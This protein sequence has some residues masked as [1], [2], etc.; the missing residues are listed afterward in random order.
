[1]TPYVFSI[2]FF[3]VSAIL[4]WLV[5]PLFHLHGSTLLVLRLL[6]ISVGTAA[7][8]AV[9]AVQ[10]R[11]KSSPASEAEV[12]DAS[13]LGTLMR[14]AQQRLAASQRASAK[15]FDSTSLVYILGGPNAA[16]T[17]IALRS[18]LD[19]ELLA[20][21]VYRDQTVVATPLSTFWY[22]QHCVLVEAG[23][24][25]RSS[26]HLWETLVRRTRPR[27]Y[28]S[29]LGAT[30][31]TRAAVVCV[32][33]ESFF[34]SDARESIADLARSTN[35]MVRTLARQLG[36]DL[37]VYVIFTKLDRVPGFAEFVRHLST[38][39]V[40]E[41]LGV[42]LP[43]SSV[44]GGLYA[45]HA[46]AAVTLSLDELFFSLR[47]F[48]VEALARQSDQPTTAP[49]YEFPRE[50][51][52]LRNNLASYL[53]ELTRPSHLSA[54]PYL[55]G[56]YF[57]GVRAH[58]SEQAV[59]A[60]AAVRKQV[61]VDSDATRIL[62]LR[63]LHGESQQPAPQVVSQKIA[64][65]CFLPRLFSEAIFADREALAGTRTSER[66]HLLRRIAL[67]TVSAALLLWIICLTISYRN[68]S[69]LESKIRES[70]SALP[71]GAPLFTLA[72]SSDLATLDRLRI[73][74]LQLEDYDRNGAPLMFR[75]GLYRGH[76]LTTPA[77]NLYFDRF[78]R[79]LL[80]R[81][82]RNIV[83]ALNALPATAPAD[84]DYFA[85]YNPL[86][87]YLITT[88]YPDKSTADFLAPVLVR[89]WINGEQSE[90]DAQKQ[91]AEEQFRFYAN[92]L[93]R[94]NPYHISPVMPAVVRARVYL[95]SFGD[96]DRI[97]QNMLAAANRV[98]PSIDFNRLFP[99][100]AATVVDSHIVPGAFTRDGFAYM[101][102]ATQHPDRYFTGEDW[103][104]GAQTAPSLQEA[105][106]AQKLAERY[107]ADFSAQWRTFLRSASVVRYR[108]LQ[109]AKEKLQSLSSP[110][111]SLLALMF[112][113]SRNTAAAS[114]PIAHE[115]QPAQALV[116]PDSTNR[117]IAAGNTNYINGLISLDGA[118]SQ[119]VQDPSAANNPS[120]AQLV[121]T[122]AV[123][124]H[125][126]V[127]QTA[128]TFN[129]DP[130]GHV[131]QTVVNLLQEPI[132]SVEDAVRGQRPEE[133]NTAGRGF[134]SAFSSLTGKYPFSRNATI[135]ATP[136]E[137]STALKPGSGT[138]W[139]FYD[140]TLKPLVTQ[141]GDSWIATPNAPVKPTAAFLQFFNRAAA[142]SKALFP[143]GV[144]S[145]SLSFHAH[146]LPSK[147]IQSVT[148]A[149]DAQRLTGSDVSKD[150]TWSPDTAQLAEL[151]ANYGSG[152]LP[153]QFNG[154]WSL[155]HLV[156]RG[157]LEQAGN[158]AR[159]AYPLEIANTP[160]VV[161]GTPLT[162]RIEIS[163]AGTS[164]LVPGSL[165]NLRCV[166]QI[167]H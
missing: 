102:N 53:V 95:N 63:S 38:E 80:A 67:G 64:Q 56:F 10:R 11:G 96:F 23:Q 119:F 66:V 132:T 144:S 134:C 116:P 90:S 21:Q 112:T 44:S 54:N 113:V 35:L 29:A 123:S 89:F 79:L 25:V 148:L 140:S 147:E 85:T 62:S 37:P 130:Q 141:Q 77:R 72:S 40:S 94:A 108:S 51:Q 30:P 13:E 167:A 71:A 7:A 6:I 137:V 31:P 122:A 104:L 101:Q 52:K 164:L 82:Q 135:E 81:T 9:F 75:W 15:S 121:V 133:L 2:L 160:I 3:A 59:S 12:R 70:A 136:A 39:E 83:T 165:N 49:V 124:A 19:P 46:T 114:P 26:A 32:S 98:A 131:E 152:S 78:E 115:F 106:L 118:L 163:G 156:D 159:L 111:S 158:P 97:Y 24:A 146:I 161:N 43:R 91:Q 61:Q 87:A 73:T 50:M 88:S 76:S 103:V 14:D 68:N 99:G 22:T 150:F 105:S 154:T 93:L 18:G 155:F 162:E 17:T 58:I 16:K 125:G 151:L 47:E 157:K 42:A 139:Q 34:G 20:G 129:L 107:A 69:R 57:S 84:A 4:S 27:I 110:N 109:D 128:Q 60:P 74:L 138:L 92:E 55:R 100:S 48:S 86:R 127:S 117:L 41:P 149:V 142:L 166:A 143:A 120:A 33:L 45:D 145:A 36:I 1:V 5:G 126:A 65:W 28:Q 153:L 8:F